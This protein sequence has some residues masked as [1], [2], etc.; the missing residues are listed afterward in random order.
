MTRLLK[1]G[2]NTPLYQIKITLAWSKPPIWRRVIVPADMTLDRFHDVIQRVMGWTDSHLHQFILGRTFYGKPDRQFADM[3]NETLSER[4]HTIAELAPA[5][6]KRFLYEYDFG[7]S[8][9]HEVLVE[10]VL[11]PDPAFRHPVCVAGANACPPDDCGGIPG[12]YEM[13]AAL[14][15]PK[16]PEHE[17]LTEWIGGKW[18]ADAF[19]LDQT[20]AALKRMK[21]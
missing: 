13:L 5:A 15:N 19:D 17:N 14:A 9:N 8:W 6:R 21:A 18:D 3:G 1:T 16:H 11:P 12:Y 20:N 4:L 10:K 7:D 2:G